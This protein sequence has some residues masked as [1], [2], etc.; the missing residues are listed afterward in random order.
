MLIYALAVLVG[1]FLLFQV[2]PVI[3]KIVLP[4]YGGSAAVWTACFGVLQVALLAGY[5]YAHA[6]IRYLK[7]RAQAALHVGLLALSALTLACTERQSEALQCGRSDVEHSATAGAHHRAA[8]LPAGH[9]RPAG[10]GMVRAPLRRVDT[11][12]AICALQRRFHVGAAELS[13]PDRAG[14]HYPGTGAHVVVGIRGVRGGV[15]RG[16]AGLAGARDRAPEEPEYRNPAGASMRCGWRCR[17]AHRR[18]CWRSPTICRRMWPRCR[19]SGYCRSAS[20]L[21]SF[22]PV[23]RRRRWYRRNPYLQLLAVAAGIDGVCGGRGQPPSCRWWFCFCSGCSPAR[24]CAT[25]SWPWLKPPPR[26]LTHFYLMI[27]AGGALAVWR[28]A[29]SRRTCSTV[30]YEMPLALVGCAGLI[31]AVLKT[32]PAL[33][34]FRRWTQPAPIATGR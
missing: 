29:W 16:G 7:P 22:H 19:C 6:L 20:N 2:E 33:D 13:V 17:R 21:L 11:L 15:R 32:D 30:I 27:A 5:L 26:L 8:L 4:W 34:W 9:H 3:G 24:W 1:A 14:I 10:A 28:S 31:L 12:L 18:C 25:A 23:L